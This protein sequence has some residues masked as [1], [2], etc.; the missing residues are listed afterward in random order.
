[1]VAAA[2]ALAFF[3]RS[4]PPAPPAASLP[5]GSPALRVLVRVD[6]RAVEKHLRVADLTRTVQNI[7]K[8]YADIVFADTA[9]LVGDGEVDEIQLVA[10]GKEQPHRARRARLDHPPHRA[11]PT[12][13]VA[14]VSVAT[15]RSLIARDWMGRRLDQLPPAQRLNYLR[16]VGWALPTRLAYLRTS[17]RDGGLINRSGSLRRHA[18]R[19]RVDQ[20]GPT[21]RR[22][23][24]AA[25]GA[26]ASQ[27]TARVR[28][29]MTGV[30]GN[31][32]SDH[33]VIWLSR[34]W[35]GH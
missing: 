31:W 2:L 16:A 21:R 18:Q 29:G 24:A 5:A 10:A 7:W 25:S 32:A 35:S 27:L 8:P 4:A 22:D 3:A 23:P 1:M 13:D 33:L 6:T 30:T 26:H 14:T 15:A 19:P 17:A 28:L 34:H 12:R 11:G 9:D 20:F